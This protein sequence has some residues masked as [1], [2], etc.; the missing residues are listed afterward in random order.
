MV[1]LLSFS[2]EEDA[3]P[4]THGTVHWTELMTRDVDAAKRFYAELSGWTFVD[5]QMGPGQPDYVLGMKNE[6]P[7]IGIVDMSDTSDD[8]S[9]DPYWMSYFAVDDVDAAVKMT[10]AAGGSLE[11]EPF[12]VPGTGRIAI[13]RDPSGA[14]IG[15][16]TP[17]PMPED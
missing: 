14:K 5:V 1:S 17:E 4:D 13:V 7:V 11:R 2:G 6:R 16:M 12:E 9:T 8:K 3:M 10:M 15:L